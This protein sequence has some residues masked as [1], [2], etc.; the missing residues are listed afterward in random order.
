MPSI[1]IGKLTTDERLQ[2]L[3]QIWDSLSD[4]P[5]AVPLTQPQHEEL[6]RRLDELDQEGRFSFVRP[7]PVPSSS[8]VTALPTP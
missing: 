7:P 3:E 2:V 5:E 1:E 6:D 8:P 4:M